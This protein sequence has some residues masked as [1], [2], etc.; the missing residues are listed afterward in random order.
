MQTS[1][2]AAVLHFLLITALMAPVLAYGQVT[3]TGTIAGT[4]T[5]QSKAVIES[6]EVTITDTSVGSTEK[7]TTNR[8]GRFVFASVK[9]GTYDVAVTMKGFRNLVVAGQELLVGGQLNLSLT[10]EVGSA[11]QTVEVTA[12][13]GAE[14][15]TL[16][17]TMSTSVAGSSL[18]ELPSVDRDAASIMYYVPTAAPKFN[19]AEGNVTSGQIAGATSDQNMY[20]LDG[21]NN[22]SGLEGDNN[23]INGGHGVIPMPMES[24]QEFTVNT[25]NMTADFSAA[26][27][28]EVIVST[29]RGSEQWHGSGYD[30]YQAGA[31]DSN[32]WYNNFEGIAKSGVISNRFGG[33]LGGP[34]TPRVAGGKTYFYVNYEGYRYPR[35][36]PTE[37][38]VPSAL[39]REG[40]LQF[41]DG[42]GNLVQYDLKSSTQC[43]ATG[44]LPCDP[45][46]IGI[47]P[48]VSELWSKYVPLPNDPHYGDLANGNYYGYIGILSYPQS[49]NFVVGRIDHD[50]GSKWRAFAS[51]RWFNDSNDNDSQVDY[52]GL[53]PGDT[54]GHPASASSTAVKPRYFV[55]GLTGTLTPSITNEF[56]YNFLRNYWHWNRAGAV[57]EISGIPDAL[58]FGEQSA[59]SSTLFAPLNIDTQ[60]ARER[61][62]GEHNSDFRDTLSWVKGTHFL[63][64]GGD[65]MHQWWHFD[66]YDDVTSGLIGP[67]VAQMASY[68]GNPAMTADVQPPPCSTSAA[69]ACLPG[70][71]LTEWNSLYANVLGMI[72]VNS[73]VISRSGKDLT[74]N[75]VGA[76]ASAYALVPTYSLYFSDAWRIK[77]NLTVT[78]GLNYGIQMPPYETHGEQDIM[79]DTQNQ[80]ISAESVLA[81]KEQAAE[82]GTLY[83]L[84]VGYTPIRALA[85]PLK[86]PYSPY[87][88]G[89]SP[90]VGVA[91]SPTWDD[92]VLG[93][94]F[95]HKTT[96]IRAGYSRFYDRS[97][98]INLV[99]SPVLGDGFIQP[100]S[101]IGPTSSGACTGAAGTTPSNIFRIGVDGNAAPAPAIAPSLASPVQPGLNGVPSINL[102]ATLDTK[103]RPGSSDELDFSIQRQL[104]G[105]MILEIGYTGRWANHI[106]TGIDTNDIPWMM[107]L[108]GQT[109]AKAWDNVYSGVTKNQ[110]ITPQPWFENALGGISSAYCAGFT[111]CTAAVASNLSPY[112]SID[113]LTDTWANLDGAFTFGP[114]TI[115]F[116]NQDSVTY[117]DTSMGYANYQ[118]MVV[119]LTKHAGNGLTLNANATYG[120]DL[121]EFSLNQEYTEANPEDPFNLRTDYGPNPWDRKL[122]MNYLGTYDLP[123]GKGR[124]WSSTNWA[125]SR[126]IGGWSLA[127]VFTWASGLPIESY[128]GSCLEWGNGYSPWCAGMVPE[129]PVLNY[130]NSAHSQVF[131][132]DGIGTNGDPANGGVG[133][134]MFKY[135]NAVYNTFRPDLVGVDG[136]SYD[137]GPIRGQKRWN[138]DLGLTKDTRISERVG[139]QLYAQALNVFNHMQ[140]ADP[141]LDLLDP[142]AF[143]VLG[144]G[145]GNGTNE[146]GSIGNGYRRIVQLGARVSF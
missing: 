31:L 32:D 2:L 107:K 16:N 39:M 140:W 113:D 24:V 73:T 115:P 119:S 49:D 71:Y 51:Y 121:G 122:T 135:P 12:S 75:P 102:G 84:P 61:L 17:S 141:S 63:Q 112:V 108:G 99:S 91:Y 85:N 129:G 57:P 21:G 41:L 125:V 55:V 43:G 87:Y 95:G 59:T 38:G 14:L 81:N 77:P 131:G 56:H 106:F 132:T 15:Q 101:C 127:P 92:G 50:F 146:Y 23:Y 68:D 19:G 98:G 105:D 35:S 42:S 128:S 126:L 26:S 5:D 25:N 28:G 109:L 54:L 33:A 139:V 83:N 9:P 142:E 65:Y 52:G 78:Y 22:S 53:L 82:N 69:T 117:N 86:Y 144:P 20:Y 100:L 138:V 76:P 70:Q 145:N 143:G 66:R 103:Y 90:R 37:M 136:R 18:I 118:A 7:Q 134:N 123:F 6:A 27:G 74:P 137:Y 64:F 104:K 79:V 67:Y 96:V 4:V 11:T 80:P 72:G 94:L 10:L 44:G 120:H 8:E 1:R 45:R 30:F 48:V 3:G 89:L 34:L 133:M 97:L 62:W 36:S 88:S 60:D 124:R 13:P 93:E 29:K 111:S 130:G 47:D 114:N 58:E 46:G 110:K 116:M 40:V